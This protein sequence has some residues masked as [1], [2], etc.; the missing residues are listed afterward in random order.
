MRK[1]IL[2]A[3]ISLD[4]F[5]AGPGGTFEHFVD[6]ENSLGFVCSLTESADAGLFG[7]VTFDMLQAHWPTA[8]DKP[9][10]TP[11]IIRY[12]NWYNKAT[13]IVL[14]RT[15]EN[16][17]NAVIVHE[18][19]SDSIQA[20]KQQEG[21]DILLFGSPTAFNALLKLNVVDTCWL[22]VHPVLFADGI[23]LFKEGR[24]PQKLVHIQSQQL[25]GGLMALQY[26]TSE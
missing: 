1:L 15:L 25:P 9:G 19:I 22:I 23:P 21:R 18:N 16:N 4:G 6:G 24:T 3:Q 8:A 11:N 13:K 10:A 2:V 20:I 7:R 26:N 14:S 12:G 5:V 17:T